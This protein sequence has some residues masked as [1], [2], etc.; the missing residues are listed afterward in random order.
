MAT[1]NE[2]Y[3]TLKSLRDMNLPIDDKLLKAADDLEEKIIKEE[4]LPSLSQNIEP[5]LNEIQ[6]DLVLVV[7][8]HPGQPLSVALSRK[9]KI[10]DFTD[11]KRLEIDPE[12]EHRDLGPRKKQVTRN[13]PATGLCVH[14]KDGTI[15]QQKDAATTF[16]TAIYEAGLIPVRELNL[17]FCGINIVSTTK[18][19]KYGNAQR[20]VSPGLYVLTHSSTKDKKKLLDRINDALQ[21]GWNIE[22]IK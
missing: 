3:T 22:I 10:S 14:R 1:L 9:A 13:A 20:E 7:E 19:K 18:D 15:L 17:R 6:R 16:T 11:A 4:I 8:H 12:V 21:I 5:L 2:L